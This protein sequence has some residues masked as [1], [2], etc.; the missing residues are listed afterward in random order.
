M[1]QPARYTS[2]HAAWLLST[3]GDLA[4]PDTTIRDVLRIVLPDWHKLTG[5][6]CTAESLEVVYHKF[7]RRLRPAATAPAVEP[8]A[9]GEY[10]APILPPDHVVI[11]IKKAGG[12]PL[13]FSTYREALATVNGNAGEFRFFAARELRASYRTILALE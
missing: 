11:A 12:E 13:I 2:E 3:V 6:T 1:S 7:K 10:K 9:P 8:H 5:H 4:T